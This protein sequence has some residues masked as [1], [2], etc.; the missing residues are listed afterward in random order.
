MKSIIKHTFEEGTIQT[1]EGKIS[2]WLRPGNDPALV[3]IPGSFN[4][5]F[6]WEKVIENLEQE[7]KIIIIE[8]RG[9]GNSWPPP[10][11][12]TIE[13]FS[14]DVIQV[15]RKL[16]LKSFFV[17]GHSI[18]GM[19]ALQV[20]KTCPEDVA[21]V[22]SIEGWTN[23]KALDAFDGNMKGTLSAEQE[24]EFDRLRENIITHWS[25]EEIIKFSNIFTQWDGYDFLK[26]TSIPI[27]EIYG[28]RGQKRPDLSELFIPQ[29]DNIHLEWIKN[30]SHN[31]MIE[32]PNKLSKLMQS[33]IKL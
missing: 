6:C 1:D 22:I 5:R 10:L 27:L 26:A 2:Y 20:A 13:Q 9:H 15:I 3:L 8:L 18:G 32:A 23:C 17:A 28:D 7:I 25:K 19:I 12:G 14:K 30:C 29:K 16:K 33:F 4:D 24:K 21:G 31:L 11:N